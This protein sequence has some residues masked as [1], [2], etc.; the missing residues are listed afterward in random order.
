[1]AK[2][3]RPPD[4]VPEPRR[5]DLITLAAGTRL[6]RVYSSAGA[7]PMSWDA[8]HTWGPVSTARFDHHDPP[9]HAP[10]KAILYA[11]MEG[12]TAVAEV[13][14]ETR[15]IDRQRRRPW[16]VAFKLVEAIE[17]LDLTGDWPTRA[18][19]SRAISTGRRDRAREWSR[20]IYDAF[21]VAGLYY[22]AALSGH[23]HSVALYERAERALP[24]SPELHIPLDHPGMDVP[25][26]EVA[27]R[28]GYLL[29]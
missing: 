17:L 25:L 29:R 22:R 16:I 23:G 6:W 4:Q 7:H 14:Q 21:D 24:A 8:F 19:A 10:G 9:P 13:F 20:A 1:M 28:F 2:L 18:G 3:P 12:P 5:E 26:Q 15:V 11:G 27:R